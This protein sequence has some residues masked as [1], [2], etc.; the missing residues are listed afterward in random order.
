MTANK[1][2]RR[3]S[4][5]GSEIAKYYQHHQ[6]PGETY[7]SPISPRYA[8]MDWGEPVCMG[9]GYYRSSHKVD[10][11]KGDRPLQCWDRACKVFLQKCHI[12]P[13][14][15]GGDCTPSNMILLCAECHRSNPHTTSVRV[16]QEWLNGI[17]PFHRKH[18]DGLL[19]AMD[20]LGVSADDLFKTEQDP[21]FKAYAVKNMVSAT[22]ESDTYSLIGLVAAFIDERQ[23]ASDQLKQTAHDT[24]A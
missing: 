5:K 17:V 11:K 14:A 24:R 16:Y 19:E 12:I 22:K 2:R 8:G 20:R 23:Q 3:R 13:F 1:G 15:L 4:V 6:L 9:C 7:S 18:A 21:E 10:I